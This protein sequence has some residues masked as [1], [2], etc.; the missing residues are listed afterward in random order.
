MDILTYCTSVFYHY[1]E[2][3]G[4]FINKITIPQSGSSSTVLDQ[5]GI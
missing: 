5:I 1:M 4:R 3:V 2:E